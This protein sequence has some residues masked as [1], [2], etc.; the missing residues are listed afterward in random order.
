MITE[1]QKIAFLKM[2][3]AFEMAP[4]MAKDNYLLTFKTKVK[5]LTGPENLNGFIRTGYVNEHGRFMN[6]WTTHITESQI[7]QLVRDEKIKKLGI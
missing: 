3:K 1:E 5:W 4:S 7:I 6:G 2:T